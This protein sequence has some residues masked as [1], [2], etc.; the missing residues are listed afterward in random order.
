MTQSEVNATTEL[1]RPF[2]YRSE[3]YGTQ[4]NI[5]RTCTVGDAVVDNYH[6]RTELGRKLIALRREYISGGGQLLGGDELDGEMQLRRGGL[7]DA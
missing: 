2:Y 3:N 7:P 4:N 1:D 5:Q 6:A